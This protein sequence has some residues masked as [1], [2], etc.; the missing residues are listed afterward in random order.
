MALADKFMAS[1]RLMRPHDVQTNGR[2]QRDEWAPNNSNTRAQGNGPFD[3]QNRTARCGELLMSV[4]KV[5]AVTSS[6]T[7]SSS[8]PVFLLWTSHSR[9]SSSRSKS[10]AGPQFHRNINK[11]GHKY[12]NKSTVANKQT[13][14]RTQF[15]RSQPKRRP[16]FENNSEK[17]SR[18][19]PVLAA[20]RL[21]GK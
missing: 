14:K 21:K 5:L 1:L 4:S 7:S 17:S 11:H 20:R 12:T 16:F 13:D 6:M 15:V 19:L 9:T 2:W 10:P 8:S 3:S 18:L